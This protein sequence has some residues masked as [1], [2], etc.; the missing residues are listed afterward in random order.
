PIYRQGA[1][2]L[3]SFDQ[4]QA[5]PIRLVTHG[6]PEVLGKLLAEARAA[7]ARGIPAEAGDWLGDIDRVAALRQPQPEVVVHRQMEVGI[8]VADLIQKTAPPE[9]R[10]LA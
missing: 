2:G 8:E 3:E 7:L 1:H 9:D 5:V 4:V 10:H 6:D